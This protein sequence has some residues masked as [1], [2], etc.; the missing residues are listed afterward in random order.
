MKKETISNILSEAVILGTVYVI[1]DWLYEKG[2]KQGFSEGFEQ[3]GSMGKLIGY[4]DCLKVV[5]D[6]TKP[7]TKEENE[8]E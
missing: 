3:G 4:V 8:S 6:R 5:T 1:C 7:E 2:R